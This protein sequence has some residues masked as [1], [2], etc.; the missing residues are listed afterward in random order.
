MN[1]VQNGKIT[2]DQKILDLA[3]MWNMQPSQEDVDG[4][5]RKDDEVRQCLSA[6]S[7]IPVESFD[8]LDEE[9]ATKLQRVVGKIKNKTMAKEAVI[10]SADPEIPNYIRFSKKD[11]GEAHTISL[12]H[13]MHL[14]RWIVMQ[15]LPKR[16][17]EQ[18]SYKVSKMIVEG[19]LVRGVGRR[20][21]DKN[22]QNE[23]G[24]IHR[25]LLSKFIPTLTP[26]ELDCFIFPDVVQCSSRN[27]Q[28][29]KWIYHTPFMQMGDLVK[30]G[31]KI[32]P[33]QVLANVRRLI[34]GVRAMHREGYVH[35][36]IKP[37]NILVGCIDGQYKLFLTDFDRVKEYLEKGCFAKGFNI[38]MGTELEKTYAFAPPEFRYGGQVL[39]GVK[40][41][42][43]DTFGLGF[44]IWTVC[45]YSFE[46]K[47]DPIYQALKGIYSPM[48]KRIPATRP[49]ID[50]VWDQ[51]EGLRIRYSE[52]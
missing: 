26:D 46:D 20:E 9:G 5:E 13:S 41:L 50:K 16:L 6:L 30:I 44:V 36:D 14:K 48:M 7:G 43:V 45:G 3:N 37:D 51:I 34:M 27:R 39:R 8:S 18:G 49:S 22:H 47:N 19:T 17:E 15:H 33:Q 11:S 12:L 38:P 10:L 52:D 32:P 31:G 23:I 24:P 21:F 28:R 2:L 4:E 35:L 29:T 40:L 25:K 1:N 42:D